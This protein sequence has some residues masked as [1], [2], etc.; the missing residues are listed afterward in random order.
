MCPGFPGFPGC[1]GA[2]SKKAKEGPER[3]T[4]THSL[5]DAGLKAADFQCRG[6]PCISNT[7]SCCFTWTNESLIHRNKSYR[8]LVAFSPV[9]CSGLICLLF[10]RDL[11]EGM[12]LFLHP[13]FCLLYSYWIKLEKHLF[14]SLNEPPPLRSLQMA[15]E[16]LKYWCLWIHFPPTSLDLSL[17]SIFSFVENLGQILISEGISVG[18]YFSFIKLKMYS[19]KWIFDSGLA[20]IL[21]KLY[22]YEVNLK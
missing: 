14:P 9:M 12:S 6:K 5:E 20:F 16:A 3:E 7:S 4:V 19:V 8:N 2:E 1:P 21:I 10:C 15:C 11:R 17:E 18:G 13:L 22:N